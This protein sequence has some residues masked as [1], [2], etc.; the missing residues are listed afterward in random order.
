MQSM[1]MRERILNRFG[2]F[3]FRVRLPRRP[4][5]FFGTGCFQFSASQ[6]N[7]NRVQSSLFSSFTSTGTRRRPFPSPSDDNDG[8]EG[9]GDHS[10]TSQLMKFDKKLNQRNR[11]H[12]DRLIECT[13]AE[14]EHF[15]N[16]FIHAL[17]TQLFAQNTR[18]N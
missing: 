6:Y 16:E 18:Q 13:R 11:G 12:P 10:R 17:K 15:T 1:A 4:L 7:F 5:S 14:A 9:G 3:S 2:C 8:G